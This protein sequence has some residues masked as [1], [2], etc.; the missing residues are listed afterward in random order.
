MD[1]KEINKIF[2]RSQL[3]LL[4]EEIIQTVNVMGNE[5]F[6]TYNN[7]RFVSINEESM[8]FDIIVD[9]KRIN[10]SLTWQVHLSNLSLLNIR[11]N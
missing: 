10:C 1:K 8:E 4:E 2:E 7:F 3:D 11:K 6:P 9:T 5:P